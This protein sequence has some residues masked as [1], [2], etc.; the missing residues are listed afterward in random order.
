M[1]MGIKQKVTK[2]GFYGFFATSGGLTGY[3]LMIALL[4]ASGV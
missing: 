2:L 4:P 3:A 1:N